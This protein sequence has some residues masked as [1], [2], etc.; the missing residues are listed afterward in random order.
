[1]PSYSR[2]GPTPSSQLQI[3]KKDLDK[4]SKM[5]IIDLPI[6]EWGNCSNVEEWWYEMSRY[7]ISHVLQRALKLVI[8]LVA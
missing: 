1:M 8:I 2:I 4:K 6:N 7:G 5:E 3:V